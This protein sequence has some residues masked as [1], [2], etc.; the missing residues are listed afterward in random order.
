[1]ISLYKQWIDNSIPLAKHCSAWLEKSQN[2]E[3]EISTIEKEKRETLEQAIENLEDAIGV[4]N[5]NVEKDYSGELILYP[6]E[7]LLFLW[8]FRKTDVDS[9]SPMDF[10]T[11]LEISWGKKPV[12]LWGNQKDSQCE[13]QNLARKVKK[14]WKN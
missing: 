6:T 3:K 1:M 12:D 2:Y 13:G 11:A 10:K 5:L 14:V 9:V 4:E 7:P 8:L